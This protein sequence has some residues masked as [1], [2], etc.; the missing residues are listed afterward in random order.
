[1]KKRFITQHIVSILT[2]LFLI[3]TSCKKNKDCPEDLD[4]SAKE[5]ISE[6]HNTYFS[7]EEVSKSGN[8]FNVYVDFSSS[9]KIAFAD[10]KTYEFY[11][12]FINSLKISTVDFFEV[13]EDK[14]SEISNMDKSDLYKL[15]KNAAKYIK[16]NAPLGQAVENIITEN[17][18]AVFITDGELWENGER[19]DP[20]AREGFT[21]WLKAGNTIEF[22][23]T[24]HIEAG[25]QKHLFYMFFIPKNKAADKQS[26]ANQFKFYLKNSAQASALVYS[27]FSF[28]NNNFK[29][30][31][32]YKSRTSGGVN[33]NAEN[34]EQN[35]YC[36]ETDKFEYSELILTWKDIVKFI[37]ASTDDNGKTIPGGEPLLNKLF[38]ETTGLEFYNIEELGIKVYDMNKEFYNYKLIKEAQKNRPTFETDESGKTSLDENNKPIVKCPGQTECFNEWGELII[39]SIFNPKTPKTIEEL[40]EIDQNAFANN[41]KSQGRGEILIK[42]HK[43]FDGTQI[44]SEDDNLH[45]IDVYL[46]KVSVKTDNNNLEKFIWEGSQVDKNR[47][48]YNSVLGALNE[49]NPEGNVLYSFYIRTSANDYKP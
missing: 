14:I 25:H 42:I 46:K 33:E 44:N 1:M 41:V 38:F 32:E 26:T 49:A 7:R 9:V 22:F 27:H 45:R 10:A 17:N 20:W 39:D 2:I 15:V 5:I 34:D 35:Y 19:D 16:T 21:K 37:R 12:L 23:V 36:S 29:L 6:F 11:E 18:E 24:D 43:N 47:S 30:V 4:I 28:S 13:A 40:F 31:K 48:I 3:T 8:N